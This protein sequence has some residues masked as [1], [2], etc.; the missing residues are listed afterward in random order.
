MFKNK[1]FVTSQPNGS[2]LQFVKDIFTASSNKEFPQKLVDTRLKDTNGD[3]VGVCI[4]Y[5]IDTKYYTAKVDFWLD[6]IDKATE[7]ETI[8]AYCEKDTEISKVIDAFVFI[9][10]KNEP[11]S[12]NTVKEW[13][14]FLDQAEPGIR[15]CIGTS[16]NQPLDMEVDAEINDWCLSNSF[17]Y[18]DM[19]EKTDIPMDKVRI[20]LALEIIQTNFWDGMVKKNAS[21]IA[22]DEDLLNE[23]RELKLAQDRDILKLG[24]EDDQDIEDMPTQHEIDKMRSELFGDIDGEDG[25]D[26]AFEA[27][28]AMREHGKNLSDEERRKMAAQVA[29]SFA[30][31]L[32]L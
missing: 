21:G 20:D 27:I 14:P 18:V 24:D 31:Q 12:F 22:E 17:D 5:E 23:I 4:P 25:L 7:K 10:D 1:I 6:E 2:T 19:D 11:S 3:L 15:L 26:K 29:L 13:A 8:K 32:G 30:A 9:F 28:Q 16:S